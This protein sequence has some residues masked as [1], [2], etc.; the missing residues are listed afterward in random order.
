MHV[1]FYGIRT[2]AYKTY[3]GKTL[4]LF[5]SETARPTAYRFMSWI[6]Y[7]ISGLVCYAFVHVCLLMPCGQLLGKG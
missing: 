1:F 4:K 6:I 2:L 3:N 7:V 5:F